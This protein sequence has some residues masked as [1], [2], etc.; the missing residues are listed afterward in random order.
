MTAKTAAGKLPQGLTWPEAPQP[1]SITEHYWVY[2]RCKGRIAKPSE[3]SGKWLVFIDKSRAEEMWDRLARATTDG[4]L[5]PSSKCGTARPNPNAPNPNETV[6][7]VYTLD[8]DDREDVMRVR[9]ALRELGVTWRIP[10]KLDS[11][12]NAGKYSVRGD[13]RVSALWA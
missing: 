11:T 10:Y 7:C 4:R 5:G 3:R 2:A 6:I 8:F 13:K 12:T 9:E 1:M